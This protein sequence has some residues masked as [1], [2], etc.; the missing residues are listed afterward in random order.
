[1][2]NVTLV[3]ERHVLE[4]RRYRAPH[5]AGEAGQILAE[6]R[7]ALVRHRRTAL[8]AGREI[9]LDFED[10]GALEVANLDCQPLDRR[11]DDAKRRKE[12]GVA[13]ARDD[14][15]RNRLGRQAE[16]ASDMGLDFGRDVGERADRARNRAGRDFI[17]RRD[18]P[19]AVARRLGIALRELEAEAVGSGVDGRGS[20]R[21][22]GVSLCSSA[23]RFSTLSSS[24]MS[25]DQQVCGLLQLHGQ[26]GV[27]HVGAGHP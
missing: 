25:G 19:L 14:L 4:C 9:L 26:R 20:G 2:R 27:E 8:L 23:R 17:A 15:G 22:S 16:F 5:H 12:R 3:P 6:H 18:Q 10:L 11:G 21:S 7:I 13:V 24:S 1:M